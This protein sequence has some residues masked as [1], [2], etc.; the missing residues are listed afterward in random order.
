M[1]F[2]CQ[3]M[4]HAQLR[5]H[6]YARLTR[7]YDQGELQALYH[8]CAHELEGWNRAAAYLHNNDAVSE[9]QLQRWER[10]MKKLESCTPVQYVFGRSE[11]YGL[12]IRCDQ[13]ALIPRP[14]TEELVDWVLQELDGGPQGVMDVGTGTGCI[15]LAL[16]SQRP[17]WQ[18]RAVDVSEAALALAKE[19]ARTLDLD[20]QWVHADALK[21]LDCS[22]VEVV[23]SNPPYIPLGDEHRVGDEVKGTEPSLALYVPAADPFVFYKAITAAAARDGV[24][25][26]FFECYDLHSEALIQS[27]QPMGF[28]ATLRRD[29]SGK[30]RLLQLRRA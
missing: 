30:P 20:V 4:T 8:W 21:A 24:Q 12:N 7:L 13:R 23:V 25:R 18:V 1:L 17:Q 28:E 5:Q 9:P 15:A 11:F 27:L 2:L 16:K 19:N 22:G 10:C 29:L 6:F 14:E 26:L 3:R